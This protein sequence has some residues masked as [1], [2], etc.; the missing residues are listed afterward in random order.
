MFSHLDKGQLLFKDQRQ[1]FRTDLSK[2]TTAMI[3]CALSERYTN[4]FANNY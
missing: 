4:V 3:R 1:L 2:W